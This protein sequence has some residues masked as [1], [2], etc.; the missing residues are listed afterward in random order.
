MI[1]RKSSTGYSSD[2]NYTYNKYKTQI[3]KEITLVNK[4]RN[5]L[6]RELK[7]TNDTLLKL[8]SQLSFADD[9]EKYQQS[10]MI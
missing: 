10:Y 4:K 9:Y 6:L 7:E 2:D 5:K 1:K 8:T 3:T